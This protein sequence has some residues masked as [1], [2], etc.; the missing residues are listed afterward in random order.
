MLLAQL[1]RLLS[2]SSCILKNTNIFEAIRV[3]KLVQSL[4]GMMML[5]LKDRAVFWGRGRI[6]RPLPSAEA[7]YSATDIDFRELYIDYVYLHFRLRSTKRQTEMS[8]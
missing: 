5:L 4:H 6:V 1:I 7:I 2:H 3:Q 8:M